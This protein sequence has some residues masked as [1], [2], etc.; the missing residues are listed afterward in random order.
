M[1]LHIRELI[2]WPE[3]PN[4]EPRIIAFDPKR[5]SVISGWSST[6]KS[7]VISIID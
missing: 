2:I 7:S 1:K 3:D 5:L 6:G 4:L